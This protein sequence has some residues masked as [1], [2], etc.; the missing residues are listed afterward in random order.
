M[1]RYFERAPFFCSFG[2]LCGGGG[3]RYL[4]LG[5]SLVGALVPFRLDSII[6]FL[7]GKQGCVRSSF[8]TRGSPF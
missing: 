3:E 1:K 5:R 7:I 2:L 8:F 6:L 4:L